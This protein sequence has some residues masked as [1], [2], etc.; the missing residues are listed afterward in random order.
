[1]NDVT[2]GV[3]RHVVRNPTSLPTGAAPSDGANLV[4]FGKR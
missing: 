2:R 1:M 4:H 3:A